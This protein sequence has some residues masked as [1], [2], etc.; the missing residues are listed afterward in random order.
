[1]VPAP[2]LGFLMISGH[3]VADNLIDDRRKVS[4]A[5]FDGPI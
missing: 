5:Y 3:S 2:P 1:M 4:F